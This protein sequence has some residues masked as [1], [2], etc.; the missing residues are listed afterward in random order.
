MP[1]SI[2]QAPAMHSG[3]DPWRDDK[4]DHSQILSSI[5][6]SNLLVPAAPQ[7]SLSDACPADLPSQVLEEDDETA[8]EPVE[9]LTPTSDSYPPAFSNH[10]QELVTSSTKSPECSPS[11][12]NPLIIN[13]AATPDSTPPKAAPASSEQ[14]HMSTS[15][16]PVRPSPLRTASHSIK[17]LFRRSNSNAHE[18]AKGDWNLNLSP[19]EA[20]FSSNGGLFSSK[21]KA[22]FSSTSRNSPVTSKSN[23]PHSPSSPSSTLNTVVN[24]VLGTSPPLQGARK[25]SISSAGL[26]LKEKIRFGATPRPQ[27]P[28]QRM[29]SPSLGDLKNQPERPGFS[30]PADAGVGLKARRMSASLPDDFT[31]DT[32]ELADEF[33]SASKVPGRRGREI[34]KGATATVKIMYRKGC[35][36]DVPYAVKEFRKRSQKENE[37]EYEKKVKSEF[38]IA[39]SLHHP[40][41]VKTVRLCTHAGRWNHVMEYC[42]HG[43]L[44]TLVQKNYLQKEDNMCLFKQLLRGVAY[45]HDN[46]IAHR[47]IKLENLLLSSE[48]HLKIT[49]FGVSEVFSGI[50]PG[51]RSA[52][53]QCGKEMGEIRKC[54]PGICGSRPYIAPEV[55]A[56]KGICS[57]KRLP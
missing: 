41:I 23:S 55:L 31:V 26:N 17:A 16:A 51:L 46:G 49:D 34:G 50:H 52:G 22:S 10:Q 13:T 28:A 45:L 15:A 47:D 30:I 11:N 43:E 54:P 1:I 18:E 5:P 29:R 38:S 27:Y 48:G 25:Y 35:S 32:C 42:S 19:K 33:V 20:V 56:K 4:H 21:R 24:G 40:N 9:P 3:S 8:S 36:K 7:I 37:E 6:P 53:G 12:S 2:S 44:F 57:L 14:Q 39:N